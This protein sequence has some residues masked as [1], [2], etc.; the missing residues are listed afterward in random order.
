VQQHVVA[1][2]LFNSSSWK[3]QH[4]ERAWFDHRESLSASQRQTCKLLTRAA[5]CA[6]HPA[7]FNA[8]GSNP[9][10]CCKICK[11][12]DL[13]NAWVFCNKKEGNGPKGS[14]TAYFKSLGSRAATQDSSNARLPVV[15]WGTFGGRCNEDGRCDSTLLLCCT[16]RS[17]FC[18]LA[19]PRKDSLPM[20]NW[21]VACRPWP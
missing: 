20:S 10:D 9:A 17:S 2:L 21:C 15:G 16:Q 14:C 5:R 6:S 1:P 3:F 12:S 7:G 18:T 11:Q 13:C 19:L 8:A 4:K